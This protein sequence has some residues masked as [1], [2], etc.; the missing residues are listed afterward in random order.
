[1]PAQPPSESWTKSNPPLYDTTFHDVHVKSHDRR[2]SRTAAAPPTSSATRSIP[3]PSHRISM[4]SKPLQSPVPRVIWFD[5]IAE[6][7]HAGRLICHAGRRVSKWSPSRMRGTTETSSGGAHASVWGVFLCVCTRVRM[8]ENPW[9]AGLLL[10]ACCV[11]DS[12]WTRDNS[13]RFLI[14]CIM[15]RHCCTTRTTV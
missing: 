6:A 3:R 8:A 10:R 15:A 5:A 4:P 7:H 2:T 9:S 13:V 1:M 11:N 14:M 12:S